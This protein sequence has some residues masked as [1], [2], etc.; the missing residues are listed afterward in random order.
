MKDLIQFTL[1]E[2]RD[3]IGDLYISRSTPYYRRIISDFCF[4][5]YDSFSKETCVQDISK[6]F[7]P[8]S[9]Y[10]DER[11]WKKI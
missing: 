8:I 5:D 6:W 2:I 10:V 4:I 1:Q 3:M 11:Y 7:R 9:C